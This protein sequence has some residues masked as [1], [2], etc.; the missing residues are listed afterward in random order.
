MLPAAPSPSAPPPDR[1]D[2][3]VSDVKKALRHW[4]GAERLGRDEAAALF[5]VDT[6]NFNTHIRPCMN[7]L[8]R[9]QHG[10]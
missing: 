10:G 4:T 1:Q 6:Y 5:D 8:M 2:L 3:S 7:K 9:L